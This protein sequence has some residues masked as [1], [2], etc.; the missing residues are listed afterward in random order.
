MLEMW[1]DSDHAPLN[2]PSLDT[3]VNNAITRI[4][5]STIWPSILYSFLYHY[6]FVL[7]GLS[8]TDLTQ[9]LL[10]VVSCLL[11]FSFR[12]EC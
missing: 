10:W 8:L 4:I 3:L 11:Y 12:K 6:T 7:M 2:R 5:G 1:S 9:K